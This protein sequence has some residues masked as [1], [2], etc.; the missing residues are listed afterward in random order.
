MD[1]F[2]EET[3]VILKEY[4]FLDIKDFRVKVTKNCLRVITEMMT[5]KVGGG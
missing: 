4:K 3:A 1:I 5:L 2:E